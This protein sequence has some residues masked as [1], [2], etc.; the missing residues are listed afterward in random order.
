MGWENDNTGMQLILRNFELDE[1]G[2]PDEEA[3][4][5]MLSGRISEMLDSEPDLLFSTL[6]RL[7]IYESK[8]KRVLHSHIEDP[9]T[10][11]ARLVLERQ[12]E[13]LKS[14]SEYGSQGEVE[15]PF[16]PI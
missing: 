6:Y 5:Q 12:I 10:G 16:N 14:R 8:I 11:L 3:L 1:R 13:K 9:A 2:H 15:D 4:I 7:D